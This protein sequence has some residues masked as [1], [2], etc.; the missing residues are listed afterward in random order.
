MALTLPHPNIQK[1]INNSPAT[2]DLWNTRYDENDENF[3]AVKDL[4]DT[5]S[6]SS[7][8]SN[9]GIVELA[10]EEEVL[11]GTDDSRAVTPKTLKKSQ[12]I[13]ITYDVVADQDGIHLVIDDRKDGVTFSE[14]QS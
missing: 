5:C 6:E 14:I 3:A 10:T 11:A 9:A 1:I 12:E 7:S 4:V 2:P 13:F 8:T